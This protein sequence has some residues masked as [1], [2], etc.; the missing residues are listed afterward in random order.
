MTVAAPKTIEEAEAWFA[1]NA[2]KADFLS[3]FGIDVEGGGVY[4][5]TLLQLKFGNDF[6][7]EIVK[8]ITAAHPGPW[9]YK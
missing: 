4:A 7:P 5:G 8:A 9:T 6:D 1:S 2:K 3:D